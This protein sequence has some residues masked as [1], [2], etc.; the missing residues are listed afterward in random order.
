MSN[1]PRRLLIV[2]DDPFVANVYQSRF[3]KEGYEAEVALDGQTAFYRLHEARFDAL[4]L[5]LSLPQ[6]HGLDILKKI[7]AQK[8][9]EKFPVVV[10]TNAYLT[11]AGFEASQA[12]ANFV[13]NK[14]SAT[15][16]QIIDAINSILMPSWP[17]SPPPEPA[18]PP[19]A[20]PSAQNMGPGSRFPTPAPLPP[21][22]PLAGT[23]VSPPPPD[24]S[25]R[26]TPSLTR[27]PVGETGSE[28][29]VLQTFLATAPQTLGRLWHL[30]HTLGNAADHAVQDDCLRE[31]SLK[32]HAMTGAASLAGLQA[33]PQ[34]GS[35]FEA[36]LQEMAMSP[37]Y[38]NA[39]TLQTTSQALDLLRVLIDKGRSADATE[40]PA[41]NILVVDDEVLSR[42][43]VAAAMKRAKLP[44][45]C[46]RDSSLALQLLEDNPFDLVI[47][48]VIMP[49]MN[50]FE[51]CAKLRDMPAH[52]NTPVMFV[53]R[54]TDFENRARSVLSG[55]T[56][57]IAKPIVLIELALKVLTLLIRA[58]C[59]E[60]SA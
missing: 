32:V 15:P 46:V 56:D 39:S 16:R 25:F 54:L 9:F 1:P 5:D 24:R 12:G 52:K 17:A 50:G 6:M 31:L 44:C 28:N 33:I 48:D 35:L 13:F 51:L 20:A 41:F 59:A 53:T 40:P 29:A 22:V 37:I 23:P 47:T 10:F 43:A 55:G 4:L 49:G 14:R 60:N 57:I 26:Q 30:H 8:R 34:L 3:E 42:R 11:Q 36:L 19:A 58:H 7:R 45:I 18:A 2:E 38:R 21:P 27:V